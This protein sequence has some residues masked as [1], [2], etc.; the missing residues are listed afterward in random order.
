[1]VATSSSLKTVTGG[2]ATQ[3]VKLNNI[4]TFAR[5]RFVQL[6]KVVSRFVSEELSLHAYLVGN[7][8]RLMPVVVSG[9]FYR[10]S[11]PDGLKL[12]GSENYP[13][14]PISAIRPLGVDQ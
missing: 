2:Y 11:P 5:W 1:M 14:S 6:L 12:F 3:L 4:N 8:S 9:H 13:Y 7:F 10:E